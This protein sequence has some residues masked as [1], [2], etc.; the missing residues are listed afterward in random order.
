MSRPPI[1]LQLYTVRDAL[2]NDPLGTLE[3]IA[4]LGYEG[5][6]T[7]LDNSAEFIAKA[8]QQGLAITGVHVGIDALKNNLEAVITGCKNLETSFAILSYVDESYRGSVENWQN[9]GKFLEGVG[10]K[11]HEAGITLCYHN[12]D[13]E[14]EKIDGQ[15]GL[16]VLLGAANPQYLQAELD[17]YWVQKGGANP[18]EYIRKYAG[19][20]PVLHIKDMTPGGQF[21]EVGEGVLDWPAIFAAAEAQG[22]TCYIV[23]QDTCPGDPIDSIAISIKNLRRMGKI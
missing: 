13:F 15:Y 16:D 4:A 10:Q 17:T 6:E 11:L 8:R 1:S 20:L 18:V 9:L 19:R 21:A 5:I 12:H 3:K 2:K 22:V 7:G 23:E 14:F